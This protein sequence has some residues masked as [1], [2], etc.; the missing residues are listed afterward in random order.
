MIPPQFRSPVEDTRPLGAG[1]S[2]TA[3]VPVAFQRYSP[4]R[5]VVPGHRL[6]VSAKKA[7]AWEIDRDSPVLLH[8]QVAAL[9]RRAIAEGEKGPGERIPQ[10]K[11]LA[12]VLGVNVNTV[13]RAFRILREEGLLQFRRGRD[14]V[15][16]GT[17]EQSAVIIRSRELLEFAR[18]RGF[19]ADELAALIRTLQ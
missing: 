1:V 13:L 11:D 19:Q 16:S 5:W 9:I 18:F 14:I 12:A 17:L 6:P 2:R 15:V 3:T 10:A 7:L 4:Y 8:D